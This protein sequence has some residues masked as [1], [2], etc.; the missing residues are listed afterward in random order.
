MLQIS[1]FLAIVV[2][3]IAGPSCNHYCSVVHTFITDGVDSLEYI[4]AAERTCGKST[5]TTCAESCNSFNGTVTG[6]ALDKTIV[7][8]KTTKYEAEVGVTFWY[9]G[10]RN[11]DKTAADCKALKEGVLA[12]VNGDADED[13]NM[14]DTAKA[15]CTKVSTCTEDCL[16]STGLQSVINSL[17]IFIALVFNL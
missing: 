9:C 5:V 1:T 8:G 6:T 14:E 16:Y 2:V 11:E 4:P 13:W 3:T 7:P 15:E 10:K 12:G 17:V